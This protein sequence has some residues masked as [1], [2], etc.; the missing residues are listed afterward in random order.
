[1]YA[2]ISIHSENYTEKVQSKILEN[3]LVNI[4]G[5]QK[6]SH[7]TFCKALHG[8]SIRLR[9][10]PAGLNGNYA[11]DTLEG[12]EEVNLIEIDLPNYSNDIIETDISNVAIA[13]SKELSWIIDEDRGLNGHD[14]LTTTA[15]Q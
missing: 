2:Y 14:R 8:E 11:Y 6:V 12:I 4:L 13:I 1:M 3:Y 7:L 15:I 10:I 5:F 9:G